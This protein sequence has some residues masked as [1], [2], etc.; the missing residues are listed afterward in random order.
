MFET[1][2]KA[3]TGAK[4]TPEQEAAVVAFIEGGFKAAEKVTEK[5]VEKPVDMTREQAVEKFG[6]QAAEAYL[7]ERKTKTIA[8]LKA[9][10]RCKLSDEQLGAK[11]QDELD[12]LVELAGSNVRAAIDFGGN[13]APKD[14]SAKTEAPAPPSLDEA[15]KA[16][17]AK[18]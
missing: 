14:L 7:T 16:D 5:I 4:A 6:F 8:A 12:Q 11:S 9:T 17:R 13:G 3:L 1:I 18:K 15:L 2:T 10:G